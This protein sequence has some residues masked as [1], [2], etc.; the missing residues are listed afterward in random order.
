MKKILIVEDEKLVLK[1]IKITLEEEGYDVFTAKNG[2]EGLATAIKEKPDLIL[3]D[4]IMPKMNGMEMLRQLRKDN[5]G[6]DAIVMLL[7]NLSESE[8]VAEATKYKVFD[9]LIKSDWK[10]SDTVEKIK[11]KLNS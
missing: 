1:S 8:K 6:K 5:W 4:I 7:T 10:L 2:E 3:L 9:Y 11:G